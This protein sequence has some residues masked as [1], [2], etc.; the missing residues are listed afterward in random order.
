MKEKSPIIEEREPSWPMSE[1]GRIIPLTVGVCAKAGKDTEQPTASAGEV[2]ANVM[3]QD[4]VMSTIFVRA[5]PPPPA[6][7]INGKMAR[8]RR[9]PRMMDDA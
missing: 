2:K 8:M 9:L 5:M 7:F 3:L 4:R 1:V 6:R